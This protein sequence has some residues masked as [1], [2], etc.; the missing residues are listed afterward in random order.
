MTD[1]IRPAIPL[2]TR[3]QA[4]SVNGEAAQCRY[5]REGAVS[6]ALPLVVQCDSKADPGYDARFAPSASARHSV[7]AN[8]GRARGRRRHWP[9]RSDVPAGTID[10]DEDWYEIALH[11]VLVLLQGRPERPWEVNLVDVELPPELNTE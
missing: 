7:P 4:E 6:T 3:R 11:A 9:E 10:R 1:S 2:Q 8:G 5:A